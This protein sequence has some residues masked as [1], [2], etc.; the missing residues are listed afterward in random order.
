VAPEQLAATAP[1][2]DGDGWPPYA[3]SRTVVQCVRTVH[4]EEWEHHGFCLRD[5]DPGHLAIHEILLRPAGQA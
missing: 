1:V 3:R 5:L 4:T 2:P